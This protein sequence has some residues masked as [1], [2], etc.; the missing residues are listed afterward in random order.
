VLKNGKYEIT[1]DKK[2]FI[3]IAKTLNIMCNNIMNYTY[4]EKKKKR[5]ILLKSPYGFS[6]GSLVVVNGE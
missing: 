3:S 5:F 6:P 1:F 4:Y 2:I